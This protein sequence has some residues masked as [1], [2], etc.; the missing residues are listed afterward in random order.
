MFLSDFLI[1]LFFCLLMSLLSQQRLSTLPPSLPF[2]PPFLHLHEDTT[3]PSL[4]PSLPHTLLSNKSI[5]SVHTNTARYTVAAH[6]AGMRKFQLFFT[7]PGKG[8]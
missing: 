1:A 2:L 8:K 7:N 4:P 3:P 5:N 6:I